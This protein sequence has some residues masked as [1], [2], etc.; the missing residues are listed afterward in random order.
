MNK[1]LFTCS[2]VL[3]LY[4]F[5]RKQNKALKNISTQKNPNPNFSILLF[6]Y[7]WAHLSKFLCRKESIQ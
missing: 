4:F 5:Y 1:H 6:L 2:L 3:L 7:F